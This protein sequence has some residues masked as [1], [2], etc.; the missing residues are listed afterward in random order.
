[1]AGDLAVNSTIGANW[2]DAYIGGFPHIGVGIELGAAYVSPETSKSIFDA[3]G[4]SLPSAFSG[5]GM[6]IPAVGATLKVGIPF[7][8]MDIGIKGGYIPPSVGKNL[9]SA[10]NVDYTNSGIQ[11]RYALVKQNLVLPN[12]S[13][14]AA[15]NYQKG[16]V[17]A[18]TGISAQSL[19]FPSGYSVNM[20]NPDLNLDW[21]SNKVD[22]TAQVSKQFFFLVPYAGAGLTVGKSSVTGGLNSNISVTGPGRLSGLETAMGSAAPDFSN[23]GFSYSAD[24][25]KA[26]FRLY[27][28]LSFRIILV[29]LD[30]QVMYIPACKAFGASI[31]ARAQ[32]LAPLFPNGAVQEVIPRQPLFYSS[33]TASVLVSPDLRQSTEHTARVKKPH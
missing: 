27:G 1:M 11:L 15:Y 7:L 19:S 22:F 32:L 33:G 14:G 21:T 24:E 4:A 29:D 31:T 28:G 18:P 8:P 26:L 13:I 30:T 2:S 10:G 16:S 25:N 9:I 20:S 6:S 23:T 17:A 12:I 3:L 5:L